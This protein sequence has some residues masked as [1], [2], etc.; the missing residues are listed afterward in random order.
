VVNHDRQNL[1]PADYNV[2]VRKCSVASKRFGAR[3]SLSKSSMVEGMAMAVL[4]RKSRVC[5]L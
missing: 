1:E 4:W 2:L 5:F 3:F